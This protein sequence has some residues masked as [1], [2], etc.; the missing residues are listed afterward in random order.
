V[1]FWHATYMLGGSRAYFAMSAFNIFDAYSLR[2][3]VFPALLASA[4]VLVAIGV[5]VPWHR[6][7]IAHAVAGIAVPVILYAMADIARR[8]GKKRE[9]HL[10]SKWGGM[11]TTVML[12]H[13][14][15][16]LDADTKADYLGFMA[17][18]LNATAPTAQQEVASP[19]AADA[20]YARCVGWLRENTRDTKKFNLLFNENVAYGFRRNL[21][22]LKWPAIVIDAVIFIAAVGYALYTRPDVESELAF[23]LL[24]LI[25]VSAGHAAYIAFACTENSVREAAV[26]YARQLLLSCEALG[27]AKPTPVTA[28]RPDAKRRSPASPPA[29][30][31]PPRRSISK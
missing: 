31:L 29:R 24:I 15:T 5:L 26:T 12:R 1:S 27:A 19:D 9:P 3:R 18:K 17:G 7:S 28:T 4:S 16:T 11:P 13:A 6:L 8:I 10:Y 21:F 14:D 22:A 2:T 30:R 23:K 25:V 20:F